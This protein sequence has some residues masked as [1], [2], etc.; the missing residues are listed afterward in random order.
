MFSILFFIY[1]DKI[2]F[3]FL[4]SFTLVHIIWKNKAF[5]SHIYAFISLN[6]FLFIYF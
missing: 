5:L 6:L 2:E 4:Y 3:Q 1:L